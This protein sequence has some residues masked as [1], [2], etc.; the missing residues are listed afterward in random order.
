MSN[1]TTFEQNIYNCFLKHFRNGEP[2]TI[3]KDFSN[4]SPTIIVQ[5]KRLSAFFSKFP[6]IT[7]DD[8]FSSPRKL[9]PDEKCPPLQFFITRPAIRAYSLAIKKREDE[10][11]DKQIQQ[12]KDSFRFIAMFCIKERIPVDDYLNHKT[13]GM[14]T[15][16]K[17]YREHH[18]NPYALMEL[19]DL[20]KYRPENEEERML[21]AGDLYDK[22]DTFKTR[23]FMSQNTRNVAK[24]AVKKIKEFA[25]KELQTKP[26]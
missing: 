4:I 13:R 18:V 5:L 10:S 14:P 23:Y 19:G 21:W 8:F 12:I 1:L 7:V 25:K 26:L 6:H 3:R 9:H 22:I 11:P 17:Y 2:Y 16:M 20:N 15:W 24:E